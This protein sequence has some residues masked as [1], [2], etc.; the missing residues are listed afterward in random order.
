MNDITTEAE[1][2]LAAASPGPWF[3]GGHN[4]SRGPFELRSWRPGWGACTV[5]GF[6]RL[7]TNSAQPTF[8]TDPHG[9][10]VTGRS[11]AIQ[12]V[13]YRTDIN[14]I[15]NPNARLIAAAPDLIARLLAE[16]HRLRGVA[17]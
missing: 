12:E 7:G 17:A 8:W 6:R 1:A 3:W 13:T 5:M 10:L 16:V 11:V 2:F 4:D 14:D 15:D 9:T